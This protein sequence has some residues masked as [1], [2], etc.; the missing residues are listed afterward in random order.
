MTAINE[1]VIRPATQDVDIFKEVYL[2]D[3]YGVADWVRPGDRI[4]DIGAHIGCFALKCAE[5][6]AGLIHCYEPH[7]GNRRV[8]NNNAVIIPSETSVIGLAIAA[9]HC[10]FALMVN[11]KPTHTAC[12]RAAAD[13]SGPPYGPAASTRVMCSSLSSA[14]S[15]ML[16]KI[17][18]LKIDCEGSEFD[19]IK[20]PDVEW[21]RVDR[22]VMEI[23][24][25]RRHEDKVAALLSNDW[26]STHFRSLGFD[27]VIKDHPVCPG[28]LWLLD[29]RKT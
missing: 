18:L 26:F 1:F 13:N 8:L 20:D 10:K 19:A 6:G 22:V 14:V 4:I 15:R 24:E 16:G 29:A 9:P 11:A 7:Y 27:V 12:H 25:I 3:E 28:D 5:H 23:H 21:S 17:R 2:H